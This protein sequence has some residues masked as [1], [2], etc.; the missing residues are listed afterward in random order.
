MRLVD[1]FESCIDDTETGNFI[2][3]E[4]KEIENLK[5]NL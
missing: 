2:K 5:T 1:A 4:K 3:D